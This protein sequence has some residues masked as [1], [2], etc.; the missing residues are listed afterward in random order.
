MVCTFPS[1]P[2]FIIE[3]AKRR[4]LVFRLCHGIAPRRIRRERVPI[5]DAGRPSLTHRGIGVWATGI[6]PDLAIVDRVITAEWHV[7]NQMNV[8]DECSGCRSSDLRSDV[9]IACRA[10]SASLV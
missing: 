4:V 2:G 9:G 3:D 8:L 5:G 1:S 7:A 6:L 10:S